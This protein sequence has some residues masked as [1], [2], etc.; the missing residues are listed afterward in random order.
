M[1]NR[2]YNKFR[3][4]IYSLIYDKKKENNRFLSLPDYFIDRWEKA[5]LMGFGEGTSVYDSCLVLGDVYIGK[6]TWIGPYTI[7]DGSGGGLT[8]GNDCDICAGVQI[9]THCT[10]NRIIKGLEMEKAPV[11]IGSNVYIG[12][13]VVIS[14]G[15]H[16]GDRVII[17]ANSFVNKDI[18]SN[19][20]VF[21][22][23]IKIIETIE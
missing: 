6:N 18:P 5:Q 12:P 9:Y 20:K 3:S 22:T 2:L 15:C 4:L 17:G 8:I 7:L 1:K 19:T 11:T 13:N 23:P 10:V 14:M 16:I 21:G